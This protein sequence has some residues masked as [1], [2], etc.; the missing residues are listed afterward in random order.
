MFAG[1]EGAKGWQLGFQK[2][3]SIRY[4]MMYYVLLYR[5]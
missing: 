3:H 2:V 4:A 5:Y 1:A